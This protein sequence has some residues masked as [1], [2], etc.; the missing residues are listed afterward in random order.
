[1]KT[2][3][4]GAGASFLAA[5]CPNSHVMLPQICS[6]RNTPRTVIQ[7]HPPA[8]SLCA[9]LLLPVL[10]S[11]HCVQLA[12]G[13]AWACPFLLTVLSWNEPITLLERTVLLITVKVTVIGCEKA[14][15]GPREVSP[16]LSLRSNWQLY[17]A[18][19]QVKSVFLPKTSFREILIS[20]VSQAAW[21]PIVD[22]ILF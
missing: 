14:I 8:P 21:S 1:M 13:P 4:A 6:S 9:S 22:N 7:T 10:E 3:K 11:H 5:S 19:L 2:L 17:P 12:A 18:Q 16:G 20:T 15:S